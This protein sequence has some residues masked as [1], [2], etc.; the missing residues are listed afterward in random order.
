MGGAGVSVGAEHLL[1]VAV[2]G[3]DHT[4]PTRRLNRRHDPSETLV[5][6][7]HRGDRRR[8]HAGVADDVN[9]IVTEQGI[10]D[11]RG[12]PPRRRAQQITDRCAHP[13]YRDALQDYFDRA[14]AT[15]PGK[16]TPHLLDEAL[17]WHTSYL[18]HGTMR[19][20]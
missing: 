1:G 13:D 16:H 9:V 17:S 3:R 6:G 2:V 8:D 7:L 11:L 14:L 15:A 5:D 10:A 18:Q 20:R 12:L 19:A 4:R